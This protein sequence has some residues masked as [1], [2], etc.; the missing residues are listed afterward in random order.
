MPM[1]WQALGRGSP[2]GQYSN[3]AWGVVTCLRTLV[4]GQVLLLLID[5]AD[6]VVLALLAMKDV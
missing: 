6:I 4:S 2:S 3:S 5:F 1:H